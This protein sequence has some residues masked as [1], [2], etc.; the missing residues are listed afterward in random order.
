M[1]G[2]RQR[3][4][5][6][7]APRLR[8]ISGASV[9]Q[10]SRTRVTG[11]SRAAS[12]VVCTGAEPPGTDSGSTP[13]HTRGPTGPASFGNHGRLENSCSVAGASA[14]GGADLARR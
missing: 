12:M 6:G 11:I 5:R 10:H 7:V 8:R 9:G 4:K 1:P 3:A 13:V 14:C 2:R